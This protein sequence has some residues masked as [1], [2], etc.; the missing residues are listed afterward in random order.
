MKPC[1]LVKSQQLAYL[2]C[3]ISRLKKQKNKQTKTDYP[4]K[5]CNPKIYIY[6]K[7]KKKKNRQLVEIP[8]Q[9]HVQ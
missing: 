8:N 1:F 6:I 7:K 3:P 5:I 2:G 9:I 4:L